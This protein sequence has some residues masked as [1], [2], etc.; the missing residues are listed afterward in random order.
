[1]VVIWVF[2]LVGDVA[3]YRTSRTNRRERAEA[4]KKGETLPPRDIWSWLFL[5][6]LGITV[7]LFVLFMVKSV[8]LMNR[9]K[10]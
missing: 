2:N 8:M 10:S 7:I 3:A 9:V 4:K 6:L 5:I 1:M